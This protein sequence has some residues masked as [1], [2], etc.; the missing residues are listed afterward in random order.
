MV[1]PVISMQVDLL[2]FVV[3]GVLL[4]SL[5]LSSFTLCSVSVLGLFLCFDFQ[6]AANELREH[7]KLITGLFALRRVLLDFILWFV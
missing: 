6:L 7:V 2:F 1:N 5:L 3:F 4:S